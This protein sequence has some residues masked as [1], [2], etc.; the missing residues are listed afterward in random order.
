MAQRSTRTADD[1]KVAEEEPGNVADAEVDAEDN[2][3]APAEAKGGD[4]AQPAA[5][6][7]KAREEDD[8]EPDPDDIEAD[9][10]TILKD[11]LASDDEDDEEDEEEEV[12]AVPAGKAKKP[13]GARI[14]PK[15]PEEFVCQS[16]FLVKHPTQ[17]GD[18]RRK[19]CNDCL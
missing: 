12:V 11:R 17:L 6:S 4:D 19:L 18:A 9:L 3:K 16:C 15:Q 10:D 1:P 13:G 8:D 5:R 14:Q 2:G 7:G